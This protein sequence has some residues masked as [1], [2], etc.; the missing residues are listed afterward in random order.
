MKTFLTLIR[1]L[2][3]ELFYM[4]KRR[5]V[6]KL[7]RRQGDDPVTAGFAFFHKD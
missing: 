1:K 7:S 3:Y 6:T 4:E 2:N 5:K